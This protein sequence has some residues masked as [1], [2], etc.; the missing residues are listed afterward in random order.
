MKNLLI[1]IALGSTF[2]G[3]L[4]AFGADRPDNDVA[5]SSVQLESF[6]KSTQA[7]EQLA[8]TVGCYAQNAN[9]QFICSTAANA[10]QCVA[11]YR[12][13]GCLWACE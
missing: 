4:S 12:G 8:C 5:I 1:V 9:Y 7:N 2:L 10:Q 13:A 11:L 6:I 3:G